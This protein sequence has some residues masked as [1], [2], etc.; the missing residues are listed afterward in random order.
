MAEKINVTVALRTEVDTVAQ[1]QA[2]YDIVCE[3]LKDNPEI[4]VSGGL[5]Q[6]LKESE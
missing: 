6:T 1:A 3:K 5:S 4:K 2:M